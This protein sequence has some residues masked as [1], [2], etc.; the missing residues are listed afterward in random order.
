LLADLDHEKRERDAMAEKAAQRTGETAEQASEAY[1]EFLALSREQMEK[2]GEA[3]VSML[4]GLAAVGS[5]WASAWAE[6]ASM[7]LEATQK[8]TACRSWDEMASVQND[9]TRACLERTCNEIARSANLTA[10]AIGASFGPLQ[11]MPRKIS[12][13]VSRQAA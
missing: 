11:E 5:G 12:E 3:S 8:L 4:N 2:M 9:L 13:R 10:E 7:S 6:Q 1:E